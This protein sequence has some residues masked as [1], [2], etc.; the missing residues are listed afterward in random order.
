MSELDWDGR[1]RMDLGER[2]AARISSNRAGAPFGSI[3]AGKN[4]SWTILVVAT[5]GATRVGVDTGGLADL[6]G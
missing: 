5:T 4:I 6:M 1:E 2:G 3:F